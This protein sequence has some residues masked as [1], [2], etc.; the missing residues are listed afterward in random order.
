MCTHT[1][2]LNIGMFLKEYCIVYSLKPQPEL[3]PFFLKVGVDFA[4]DFAR[5]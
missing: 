1:I 3:V 4:M 2:Y 5:I